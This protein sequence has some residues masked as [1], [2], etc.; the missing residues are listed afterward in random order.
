MEPVVIDDGLIEVKVTS[1]DV[2]AGT[3]ACEVMN[4][5]KLGTKKGCNLP[6]VDVDLPALSEK[7]Q[8]DLAFAVS[9]NV[10]LELSSSALDD[11]TENSAL[12]NCTRHAA[13]LQ[14]L[15]FGGQ[16][17]WHYLLICFT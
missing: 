11:L 2:A 1:I 7:D 12:E 16:E 6:E 14:S 4:T 8:A 15:V 5:G 17:S 13:P 9:Q 3:M 10:G